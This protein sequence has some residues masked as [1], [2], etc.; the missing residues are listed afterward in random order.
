MGISSQ[1]KIRKFMVYYDAK[2]TD[3]PVDKLIVNRLKVI[4]MH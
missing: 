4:V 1:G 3:M 2:W